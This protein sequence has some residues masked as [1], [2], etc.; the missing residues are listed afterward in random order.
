MLPLLGKFAKSRIFLKISDF[1]KKIG[2]LGTFSEW[3]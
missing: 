1:G 3:G 2:E